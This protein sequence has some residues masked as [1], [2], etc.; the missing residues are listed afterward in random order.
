LY[1]NRVV[2]VDDVMTT[3]SSLFTAARLLKAAGASVVTGLVL[4]RT[5]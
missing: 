3:G 4:A 5:E 1:D 2:L